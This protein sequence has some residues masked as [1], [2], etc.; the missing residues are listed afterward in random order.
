MQ[1]WGVYFSVV[2]GLGT[3]SQKPLVPIMATQTASAHALVLRK[4]VAG[5]LGKED[6]WWRLKATWPG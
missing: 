2:G 6:M 1:N 4:G 5:L 3:K